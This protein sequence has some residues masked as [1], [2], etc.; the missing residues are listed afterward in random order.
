[1]NSLNSTWEKKRRSIVYIRS[2]WSLSNKLNLSP[3]LDLTIKQAK[4]KHNNMIVNK[5][6]NKLKIKIIVLMGRELV[7]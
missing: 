3:N 5:L 2:F 1:M 6:V 4:P 7:N